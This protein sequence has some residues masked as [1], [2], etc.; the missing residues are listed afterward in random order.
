MWK[1]AVVT[2]QLHQRYVRGESTDERM[3][4]QAGHP[5]RLAARTER[6]LADLPGGS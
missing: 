6:L 4:A 3:A 1:N 5:P 2:Q